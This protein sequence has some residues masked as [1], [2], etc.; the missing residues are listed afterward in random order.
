MY[1]EP[2]I[3]YGDKGFTEMYGSTQQNTIGIIGKKFNDLLKPYGEKVT[4]QYFSND[5]VFGFTIPEKLK[6]KILNNEH[7]FPLMDGNPQQ[8]TFFDEPAMA[9]LSDNTY[10]E[11]Y[12][13]YYLNPRHYGGTWQYHQENY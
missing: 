11:A 6:E 4:I 3:F 1:L 13:H 9:T 5:D 10:V 2:G 8:M 12:P 7:S